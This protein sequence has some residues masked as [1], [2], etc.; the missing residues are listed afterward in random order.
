[1]AEIANLVFVVETHVQN[2]SVSAQYQSRFRLSLLMKSQERLQ[3]QA[4]D[5][6]SVITEDGFV[7][8]NEIFN[9]FEA[10][11]GVEKDLFMPEV[12]GHAPPLPIR[13]FLQID[14]RTVMRVD[15]KTLDADAEKVIHCI[16]NNRTSSDIQ[17]RFGAP[18]C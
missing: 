15:D 6:V 5:H 16:G 1:M 13:K 7:F 10:S 14:I 11:G 3:G 12:D 4:G 18:L 17:E 9:I 2:G 8:T